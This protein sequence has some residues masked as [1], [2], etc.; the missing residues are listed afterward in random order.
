MPKRKTRLTLA[1]IGLIVLMILVSAWEVMTRKPGRGPIP[2]PGGSA[3]TTPQ[4]VPL[5]VVIPGT[6]PPDVQEMATRLRSSRVGYAVV[7][8]DRTYLIISTGSDSLRL[9]LDRAEGLPGTGSPTF[10]TVRLT[11]SSTGERL[12]ILAS[13]L[14]RADFR[15][16]LDGTN[17]GIP[18]LRNPD[19]LPVAPLPEAENL[20]VLNPAAGQVIASWPLRVA[21]FARVSEAQLTVT[22]T[23]AKGRVLGRSYTVVAAGAPAWGSFV[24]DLRLEAAQTPESGFLVFEGPANVKV[25]VPIRFNRV[26]PPQLG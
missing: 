11:S 4:P 3:A 16:D 20:V 25:S 15:F 13:A 2:R 1:A 14:T 10:V 23:D 19:N 8:P 22:V 18:T 9:R 6:A 24:A 7:K 17:A 26:R 12:L 5:T 21:G